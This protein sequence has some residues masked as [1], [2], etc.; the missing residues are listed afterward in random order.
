MVG[1]VEADG[2]ELADVG[3]RAA[4]ARLAPDQ[5]QL[6]ELELAQL[7]QRGIAELLGADVLDHRAEVAQLAVV[8]DEAG[9][10]LPRIAVANEFHE[11]LS[12]W[13]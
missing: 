9:L 11:V 7:G 10:L 8:V 4:V 2:D 6:V 13:S 5:R 3:D 12:S 1:V